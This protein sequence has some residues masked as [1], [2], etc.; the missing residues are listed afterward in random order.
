MVCAATHADTGPGRAGGQIVAS[1]K[2]VPCAPSTVA[3]DQAQARQTGICTQLH[4]LESRSAVRLR[5][6]AVRPRSSSLAGRRQARKHTWNCKAHAQRGRAGARQSNMPCRHT[7]DRLGCARVQCIPSV[8]SCVYELSH[9]F[10][11]TPELGS[12]NRAN[13]N[14]SHRRAASEGRPGGDLRAGHDGG[15][16]LWLELRVSKRNASPAVPL[17]HTLSWSVPGRDRPCISRGDLSLR[18]VPRPCNR[19]THLP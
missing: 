11:F 9:H 8:A 14:A 1:A 7:Q 3:S 17:T 16:G 18:R 13:Q 12:T 5:R 2:A 4:A 6:S 19:G 10:H 15:A